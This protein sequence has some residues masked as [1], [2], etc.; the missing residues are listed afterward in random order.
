MD[1]LPTTAPFPIAH[2][3]GPAAAA[4]SLEFTAVYREHFTF[5][6]RNLRRLRVAEDAL[7]D[8]AQEVFL[9]VHRR[10]AEFE[11]RSSLKTWLFGIL[12]NT[13]RHHRRARARRR[14][15]EPLSDSLPDTQGPDGLECAA[16]TEA[17]AL[18]H[19]FLDELDD[20]LRVPFVMARLEQLSA[21]EVALATGVNLHTVH[22]R[23]RTAERRFEEKVARHHARARWSAR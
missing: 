17:V 8:A 6:W 13:V 2:G 20:E 23:I 19:Q 7:D 1:D 12:L 22:S 14:D 9:T 21:P 18:L 15:P 4:P 5:V 10:L 16:R 11:G 3:E